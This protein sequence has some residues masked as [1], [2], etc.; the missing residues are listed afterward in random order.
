MYILENTSWNSRFWVRNGGQVW[1]WE[2]LITFRWLQRLYCYHNVQVIFLI[3]DSIEEKGGR[4]RLNV[5]FRCG[6][7]DFQIQS[8]SNLMVFWRSDFFLFVLTSTEVSFLLVYRKEL[9]SRAEKG[10]N[11]P[12]HAI[13]IGKLN[14]FPVSPS[15]SKSDAWFVVRSQHLLVASWQQTRHS[16]SGHPER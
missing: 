9:S 8:S 5:T 15:C 12:V 1:F 14:G 2:Y 6:F 10:Q 7:M 13:T 4:E 16:Q 3:K 11:Q